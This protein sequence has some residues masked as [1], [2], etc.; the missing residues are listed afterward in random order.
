MQRQFLEKRN[1]S[2]EALRQ[3]VPGRD[4]WRSIPGKTGKPSGCSRKP[5]LLKMLTNQ[6]PH[7]NHPV[8][9][10]L[11]TVYQ[12]EEQVL[13][14]L[15]DL[16]DMRIMFSRAFTTFTDC[17]LTFLSFVQLQLFFHLFCFRFLL[18]SLIIFL[19]YYLKKKGDV[20]TFTSFDWLIY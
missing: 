3:V 17:L 9:Q 18:W 13:E 1:M 7:Q 19:F 4:S 14:M 5:H 15:S 8:T 16:L 6:N 2:T 12:Y 20:T 11:L 10:L